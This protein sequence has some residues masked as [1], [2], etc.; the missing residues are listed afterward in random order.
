MEK[1]ALYLFFVENVKGKDGDIGGYMPLQ[2][3]A[4]FIYDLP[5]NELIAHELGHGAFNL[6]HTFS[7]DGFIAAQGSTDNLMD[8]KGGTDL[9]MHQWKKVL[10]PERVFL[11]FL[12]GEEEGEMK[13]ITGTAIAIIS[14]STMTKDKIFIYNDTSKLVKVKFETTDT[15][16]TKM[17]FKLTASLEGSKT[18]LSYPKTGYDTLI[19]NKEK[20]IRL[21]SIPEGTYTLSCEL[22]KTE[23]STL[24]YI[25]KQ[26]YEITKDQLKS[27]F[28]DTDDKRL[29]DVV[30]AINENSLLY[31]IDTKERMAHF[32]GQ[33]GAETGGLKKLAEDYSYSAERIFDIFLKG[34]EL[35]NDT[36]SKTGY[37]FKYCDLIEK[38]NG[39]NLIT[40]T[41]FICDSTISVKIDKNNKCAWTYESF[42][43]TYNIKTEY[44]KSTDLFDYVYGCRMGNGAKSTKDGSTYL[45]KGFMHITGKDGYKTISVEWNK[46]YPDDKKEFHGK[47]IN[48]LETDVEVAMKAAM[49]FWKIKKY[50]NKSANEYADNNDYELLT[51]LINGG[52]NGKTERETY[53]KNLLKEFK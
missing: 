7:S 44:I 49:I 45:G 43:S 36:T 29:E 52:T 40:C 18:T 27:V 8:Y 21:D 12:E 13:K 51:K 32:L 48:L 39:T 19:F 10:D 33:I 47:D 46:L 3:Q 50:N 28:P 25:R 42:D 4:G 38:Y 37:T 5:N 6:W 23:Y 53:T 30:K 9:W 16:K 11:S 22:G 14:D 31:A 34:V 2:R 15:S 41:G 1:E 35:R 26:K 24:F 20:H 17:T